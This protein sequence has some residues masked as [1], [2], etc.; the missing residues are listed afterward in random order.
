MKKGEF[1]LS[2]ISSLILVLVAALVLIL[3]I[4][5]LRDKIKEILELLLDVLRL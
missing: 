5:F 1:A 3:L 2:K 4:Y